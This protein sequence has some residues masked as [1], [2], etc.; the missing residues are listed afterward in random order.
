MNFL[1]AEKIISRLNNDYVKIWEDICNI[2]SPTN[3]KQGVDR[4]GNYFANL[5]NEKGFAVEK[6]EQKVSGDVVRI[7]LN[8]DSK[9]KMITL[10]AHIDTVHEL[11]SFGYP[12]V[13]FK[14][15]KIIGPGVRDCKGGAVAAFFAL[16]VLNECGFKSNPVQFLIQTDEECSS[17]LSNKETIK[18]IIEKSKDSLAFFNLEGYVNGE[19]CLERKGII[20]FKLSVKGIKSH[21]AL[22]ATS[23][24]NAIV[25]AANKII[26]INKINDDKGTTCCVSLLNCDGSVNTVPD[27][28]DIFVNT[29]YVTKNDGEIIKEKIK[30]IADTAYVEGCTTEFCVYSE[31]IPMELTEKSV[32]LLNEVNESFKQNNLPVLVPSKHNGG[33]DAAYVVSNSIP[34]IDSIGVNGGSIHTT[35]EFAYVDSLSESVKRL[36]SAIFYLSKGDLN[37]K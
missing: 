3:Y 28:C 21:A 15:N 26:E 35:D 17:V 36:I 6:L 18:Y 19:A 13:T 29:R 9:G 33:S 7:I 8:P 14:G 30:K 16:D 37:E 12:P 23:G 4:V 11:G 20:T 34:C 32:E 31:R 27:Y 1:S 24:A 22:C 2:E 10:S 5:A 25:E